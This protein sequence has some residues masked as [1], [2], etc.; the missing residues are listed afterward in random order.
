MQVRPQ[1][2]QLD[3]SS[4]DDSIVP[5]LA[6]G[7]EI[8]LLVRNMLDYQLVSAGIGIRSRFL[9]ETNEVSAS[10]R[11]GWGRVDVLVNNDAMT[12]VGS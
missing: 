5:W 9:P 4:I 10:L 11:L 3:A 6:Y 1:G 7:E 2:G 12:R 8:A